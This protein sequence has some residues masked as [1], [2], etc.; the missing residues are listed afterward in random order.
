[1][2]VYYIDISY[3]IGGLRYQQMIEV[4]GLARAYLG[5][6]V[7]ALQTQTVLPLA[8]CSLLVM[9]STLVIGK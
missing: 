6:T 5:Y 1:M 2:D 3:L 4:I 8:I 9:T 7:P